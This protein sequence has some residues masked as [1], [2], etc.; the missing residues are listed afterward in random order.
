MLPLKNCSDFDQL[1]TKAKNRLR[2][3]RI[4]TLEELA[5]FLANPK[6]MKET[7][8]VGKVT[9]KELRDFFQKV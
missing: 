7:Q 9:M 8:G 1:S 3:C 5:A 4:T 6:S 2:F